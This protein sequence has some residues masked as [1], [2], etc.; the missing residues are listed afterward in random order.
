ML[1]NGHHQWSHIYIHSDKSIFTRNGLWSRCEHVTH[2]EWIHQWL[3]VNGLYINSCFH[4][5][6]QDEQLWGNQ[7]GMGDPTVGFFYRGFSQILSWKCWS[8]SKQRNIPFLYT[9]PN[10]SLIQLLG[11]WNH[12]KH[13]QKIMSFTSVVEIE[14]VGKNTLHGFILEFLCCQVNQTRSTNS[15]TSLKLAGIFK[16]STDKV[17][18]NPSRSG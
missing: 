4:I 8:E 1:E 2:V 11:D 6:T 16:G 15:K 10:L 13:C 9:L 17:F 7:S 14:K 18:M 5:I 3:E 12:K